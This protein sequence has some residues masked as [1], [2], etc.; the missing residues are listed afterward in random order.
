M[1]PAH[2]NQDS[3]SWLDAC[4]TWPVH[5]A[6]R[7]FENF[8]RHVYTQ[9]RDLPDLTR[10]TEGLL[11][12][13]EH[14]RVEPKAFLHYAAP[15]LEAL[16]QELG[17]SWDSFKH[18]LIENGLS[19]IEL[20]AG[21]LADVGFWTSRGFEVFETMATYRL[22][23]SARHETDARIRDYR[24][25]DFPAIHRIHQR[26]SPEAWWLSETAYLDWLQKVHSRVLVIDGIVAGYT[27][28][29]LQP[30]QGLFDGLA[31]DPDYRRQGLASALVKDAL[32]LAHQREVTRIDLFVLTENEPA[33]RLY[34]QF[35]FHRSGEQ[36]RLQTTL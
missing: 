14:T 9:I 36:V 28:L 6:R 17:H 12:H 10:L 23:L 13:A 1:Q 15:H 29:R 30:P 31:V 19:R 18:A 5:S 7:S 11:L 35:G 3:T 4:E 21:A 24:V 22:D 8:S 26:T 33:I 32:Q 20:W 16:N 34:E 27:H 2:A 25:E